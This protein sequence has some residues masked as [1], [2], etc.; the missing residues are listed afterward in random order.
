MTPTWLTSFLCTFFPAFFIK[1]VAALVIGRKVSDCRG[2]LEW[3]LGGPAPSEPPS[4]GSFTP[5]LPAPWTTLK[6]L[7][8]RWPLEEWLEVH[9]LQ[10]NLTK[11]TW[12]CSSDFLRMMLSRHIGSVRGGEAVGRCCHWA[13]NNTFITAP[14]ATRRKKNLFYLFT[15]WAVTVSC[16]ELT[17]MRLCG[18]FYVAVMNCP[19]AGA[20]NSGSTDPAVIEVMV[21]TP[22]LLTLDPASEIGIIYCKCISP[23]LF[24]TTPPSQYVPH[25]HPGLPSSSL[26]FYPFPSKL[27]ATCLSGKSS[28]CPTRLLRSCLWEPQTT[29]PLISYSTQG[30]WIT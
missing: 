2:S 8:L 19:E 27:S 13:S 9:L 3:I 28:S 25:P 21:S 12:R 23:C 18:F 16:S 24:L 30:C 4:A 7:T 17:K 20:G 26:F 22:A 11:H 10:L 15:T 14:K 29:H 1:V 6:G 5:H